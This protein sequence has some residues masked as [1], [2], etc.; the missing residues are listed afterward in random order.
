[1]M[2]QNLFRVNFNLKIM[3]IYLGMSDV[4]TQLHVMSSLSEAEVESSPDEASASSSS[5]STT[6]TT[7][8]TSTL[9]EQVHKLVC[10]S[11]GIDINRTLP[12]VV[13]LKRASAA[14]ATL[15][16][17][18]VEYDRGSSGCG[19]GGDSSGRAG[20]DDDAEDD[21]VA[22]EA[23]SAWF[24]E[25]RR[26]EHHLQVVRLEAGQWLSD[27]STSPAA[28]IVRSTTSGENAAKKKKGDDGTNTKSGDGDGGK[29]QLEARKWNGQRER[30]GTTLK[31]GDMLGVLPLLTSSF[32]DWFGGSSSSD[33]G[34]GG[35]DGGSSTSGEPGW[36]AHLSARNVGTSAVELVR[37]PQVCVSR[38]H[39]VDAVAAD[40]AY[41]GF[42]CGHRQTSVRTH[43]RMRV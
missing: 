27:L 19:G 41:H 32:K 28:Y 34:G 11:L 36:L 8:T 14:K 38:F 40:A 4:G 9:E 16:S 30:V 23:R 18:S 37:I 33:S 42:M 13:D 17:D 43:A 7:S 39:G 2:L 26:H 24:D 10:S 29:L 5:S 31:Q 3:H 15:R 21:D 25:L 20:G 35:S 1:M 22:R 12:A 6:T